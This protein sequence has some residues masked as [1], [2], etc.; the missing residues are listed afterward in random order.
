ME[1]GCQLAKIQLLSFKSHTNVGDFKQIMHVSSMYLCTISIIHRKR[2]IYIY[3]RERV[4]LYIYV[5]KIYIYTDT[6]YILPG[7]MTPAAQLRRLR[8]FGFFLVF[9]IR[10]SFFWMPGSTDRMI[11]FNAAQNR[12]CSNLRSATVRD[13]SV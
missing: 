3:E 12:T 6:G 2:Y 4:Y 8:S 9:F 11:P 5:I 10:F 7:S 13:S 1:A